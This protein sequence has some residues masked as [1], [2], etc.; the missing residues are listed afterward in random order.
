MNYALTKLNDYTFLAQLEGNLY[1]SPNR[2]HRQSIHETGKPSYYAFTHPKEHYFFPTI[3]VFFRKYFPDKRGLVINIVGTKINSDYGYKY[4]TYSDKDL[5]QELSHY[6][7][8]TKGRHYSIIGDAKYSRPL[9]NMTWLSGVNYYQGYTKNV[10]DGKDN[11]VNSMHN[12]NVYAYTQISGALKKIQY[13]LGVGVSYSQY[14]QG[15]EHYNYFLIRPSINLNYKIAA[16][17]NLR[18]TFELTP[19]SPSLSSL[20]NNRQ[21]FNEFEYH[22]GNPNL[23][24]YSRMTQMLTFS[25]RHPL[26]D[27]TLRHLG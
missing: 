6:G 8:D 19:N 15:E 18:Y 24:P 21:Q 10:Y 26:G 11:T 20:S 25:Y 13:L 16:K 1:D 27:G 9:G 2:G 22:V 3:D 14:N 5:T 23:K 4:N 7:Y 17:G 12:G